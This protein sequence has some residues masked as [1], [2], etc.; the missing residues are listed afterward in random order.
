M[1]FARPLRAA[2]P[3][4]IWYDRSVVPAAATI[5]SRVSCPVALQQEPAFWF[6][7]S[8]KLTEEFP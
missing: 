6:T 1:P 4:Q 8:Q 3:D 5:D 7:K 2:S